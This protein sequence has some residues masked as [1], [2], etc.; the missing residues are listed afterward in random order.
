V[1]PNFFALGLGALLLLVLA[2]TAA[3][4]APHN[5]IVMIADG[6]GPE[7]TAAA[8]AYKGAP[9]V[10]ESAPNSAQMTTQAV[11]FSGDLV[12]TDSGA[13]ATAMATGRKVI[14]T[15]ISKAIPGDQSD[16]ETSLEYWQDRGKRAGLVTTSYIED[17]TPAAFGAHTISRIFTPEIATDYLNETR[18]NVLMGGIAVPNLGMNPTDAA[19]AG[20][21]VVQSR[22]ELAA[23]DLMTETHISG[24]FVGT[25]PASSDGAMPYEFDYEIGLDDG[26]D[27]LPFLSEMTSSALSLLSQDPDGFFLMVEQEH[28]DRS[29]HLN[30]IPGNHKIERNVFASLEFERS[31][32]VV[33]D[34]I[35][36]Q[37]NPEKT[38]LVVLADHETGGL[39]VVQ[40]NGAGNFPTVTWQGNDHT[41]TLIDVFAWGENAHLVSGLIDNTDIHR[42]TTATELGVAIDIKPGSDANPINPGSRG[43][44]PV[45]ILG[46]DSFDVADVDVTTLAFGPAGASLA[47]RNGPEPKDA[48]HDGIRDL[49]AHF[50][51]AES[52]IGVGA[53]EACVTGELLDGT[54]FEGCDAITTQTPSG[55]CGLGFELAVVL[56][57]LRWLTGRGRKRR[58]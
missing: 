50:L 26:Y 31:V 25:N 16:L 47:H 21:T 36:Q 19:A 8:R 44:V 48:N 3:G 24:Q 17:A 27:T 57:P 39:E 9:L 22:A 5:V 51:V 35:G 6:M 53:T 41:D 52:G 55:R 29:G 11:N 18:P 46:S 37:Q 7:H 30:D 49:L 45:A 43:V 33:L 42:I 4:G 32:Q 38:L 34:W 56:A 15:V 40:D 23:L 1:K 58:A 20:Y 12:T 28:T 10:Y 14:F 13:S 54:T 2:T